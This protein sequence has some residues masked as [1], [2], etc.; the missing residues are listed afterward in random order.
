M[1]QAIVYTSNTGTTAQY[2]QLLGQELGLPVCSLK[3]AQTRVPAGAPVLYLGW[4]M[5]GGIQGY[6]NAR[7]RYQLRAVCAVG[8]GPTGSQ[9]EEVRQKNALPTELPLF[10]LQGGFEL[11]KLRGVYRMMMEV[12]A[13][14]AGKGLADKKDRTPMEDTMLDMLLNGG[15]RVSP[16]NLSQVLAWYRNSEKI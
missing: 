16:D 2:A 13:R 1:L 14:T 12:M 15:S 11:K 3:E 7:R 5:A 8:M 4:L 10:T 9:L 6:K